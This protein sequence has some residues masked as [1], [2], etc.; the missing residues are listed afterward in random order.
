MATNLIINID[1]TTGIHYGAI[2]EH[3]PESFIWE[4]F[5]SVYKTEC[6]ECG[7]VSKETECQK[8]GFDF[9]DIDGEPSYY[10]Y[11]GDSD[12]TLEYSDT[13]NAFFVTK[14]PYYTFAALCSPCAPNAGNLD[15]PRDETR[16]GVK[17]YCLGHDYFEN[18]APYPVFDVATDKPVLSARYTYHVDLDERG[19]FN[20]HVE[21]S[22]GDSVIGWNLP[23]YVC[24]VCGSKYMGCDCEIDEDQDDAIENWDI[25]SPDWGIMK[26]NRD[27]AGLCAHLVES[28]ILPK[29][30]RLELED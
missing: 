5:N 18:G 16:G 1:A 17:T 12:Y 14:S 29:D 20:A 8:C 15:T 21:N 9:G 22:N 28:G 4:D 23:E 11:T 26:H 3:A 27:V 7:T 24:A 30:A 25:L 2:S 19:Q 10:E 13:L 6:P